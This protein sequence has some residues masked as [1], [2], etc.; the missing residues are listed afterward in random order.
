MSS[1]RATFVEL[2]ER[3]ETTIVHPQPETTLT[4]YV[5]QQF[6]NMLGEFANN[7]NGGTGREVKSLSVE[8]AFI[9]NLP[10]Q[11]RDILQLMDQEIY[12]LDDLRPIK[13][14]LLCL[15]I[16]ASRNGKK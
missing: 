13:Q 15:V 10:T 5:K 2:C 12:S 4:N 3:L 11:I 6:L 14:S 9:R 16:M 1:N 7:L 8:V